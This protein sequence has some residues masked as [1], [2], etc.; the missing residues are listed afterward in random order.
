MKKIGEI[1][2]EKGFIRPHHLQTVLDMQKAKHDGLKVGELLLQNNYINTQQYAVLLEEISMLE[3]KQQI[4][5]DWIRRY[6]GVDP[7][8]VG[9]YIIL[10]NFFNYLEIACAVFGIHDISLGERMM[11][12]TVLLNESI[13][14][15]CVRMGSPNMAL[16]VDIFSALNP[17]C[18]VFIGKCGGVK[19]QLQIGDY[20]LPS[21]A[22]RAD[23]TSDLYLNPMIP[24]LP[25]FTI[26]TILAKKLY[27]SQRNYYTGV[28]HTTNKRLW[29]FDRDFCRLLKIK[30]S[31]LIWRLLHFLA[32]DSRMMSL[33]ELYYW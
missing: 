20:I 11:F 14:I 9:K 33:S 13:A 30:L 28:V 5:Y 1:A 10:T 7:E 8:K 27:E 2:L 4:C 17:A 29:E 18:F 16:A 15:V 6:C 22:I 19:R 32:S 12:P 26:Q 21:S 25:S 23:G 24:S 3:K 31:R